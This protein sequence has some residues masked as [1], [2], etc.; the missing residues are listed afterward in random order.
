MNCVSFIHLRITVVE[1]D[2]T[3]SLFLENGLAALQANDFEGE[4][5]GLHLLT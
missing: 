5:A 4:T 2:L 1:A 3:V